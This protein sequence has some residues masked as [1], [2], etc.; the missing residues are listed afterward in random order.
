MVAARHN[1]FCRL[2]DLKNEAAVET[3]LVN[4][5]LV[6]F[7][8]PDSRV[9]TKEAIQSLPVPKGSTTEDYRPDY[10]LLDSGNKPVIVVDAKHPDEPI[11]SWIYQ[12]VGYAAAINRTY[13]AGENPVKYGVL[14]NG[15]NLAVYPWDS[16][17]PIFYLG[18]ED[19]VEENSAFSA[20][21]SQ[22][23]YG[24]FN[25]VP[26]EGTDFAFSRPELT[27]L[28]KVF[29]QCHDVIWKKEKQGPTW[30]FYE[31]VKIIFVKMRQDRQIHQKLD[32][33][34][35]VTKNDF[36]FAVHWLESLEPTTPNPFDTILFNDV[37]NEIEAQ[38]QKGLKKP[39]FAP[40]ETLRLTPSTTKEVVRMLEHYDLHGIDE[41]LNGRMFETFLTA[42]I[43]GKELGQYFTPRPI[44]RY[45]TMTSGLQVTGGKVPYVLDGCCGTGGFLIEAMAV[46]VQQVDGHAALSS[47]DRDELKKT[48]QDK[49]LYG[50][51]AN[52]DLSRVARL[53]MYLHGDGGSRIYHA[54]ALDKEVGIEPG[55]SKDVEDGRK[56]LRK[57]VVDE[58]LRFDVVL[59]NPPFSMSYQAKDAVEKTILQ[60][61]K[62]A[63]TKGGKVA[64]SEKSSI[65]FVERYLDVLNDGGDLLTVIDDTIL[66]GPSAQKHRDFIREHFIIRQVVSLPF[67][68]F[69]KAQANI[70]TSILHLRKKRPE[71]QQGAVFM[72][73]TNNV[74]HDDHKHDTP[75]RDNLGIVASYYSQWLSGADPA[76][77][78]IRNEDPE[79]PLGCPLQI[80]T[81]AP[82]QLQ[83]RLDAFY[84]A[85]E[86]MEL[87]EQLE[88]AAGR[89]RI[90]LMRGSDLSIVK[91]LSGG[92]V[93]ELH[94][95]EFRYFEIGDVTRYGAIV[96]SRQGAIEDLP[97]R[98]R[99]KVQ[100]NDV[101]F[102]KNNS[103]RG[104][105]VVIPE[106]FDGA[107]VTTGFLGIRPESPEEA[108]IWW[109]VLC[110]EAVRKQ[111]YYLAV[112]ASQPEIRPEI[113]RDEFLLPYPTGDARE[114]LLLEAKAL[115]EAQGKIYVNLQS[116][117]SVQEEMLTAGPEAE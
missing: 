74:G 60:Q 15:R 22:L 79:E 72:A 31:F 24:V 23:A 32:E 69:F 26:V 102:A 114:H 112:S 111:I 39:I 28:T 89:E 67:N 12:V 62:V 46:L 115:Q 47:Y 104:T 45:M 78:I 14:C 106:D 21:A 17:T 52:E 101:V 83:D 61:Y 42:T 65:L 116:V 50:I 108:L 43:R 44:V 54:E 29:N 5:L 71:E 96:N 63:K 56:E 16:N 20:L 40:G 86:L 105:T 64:G 51:E 75:H 8:Y 107:L 103:S 55:L 85:P 70:K 53:N 25:E 9:R 38:I 99:L 6:H 97:T 113:F 13:P 57:T 100:A 2:E 82:D 19:L 10:V 110:S 87:R 92:N 58:G 37:R 35:I 73:I 76:P 90:Q 49:R 36:V 34:R 98:G 7:G 41:D 94:G 48:I 18:F 4:R 27:T 95:Q 84:Y 77:T 91:D 1:M 81:V 68:A 33:G 66:N 3:F 88:E 80:F 11:D 93:K 59:T 30:A 109:S 117:R